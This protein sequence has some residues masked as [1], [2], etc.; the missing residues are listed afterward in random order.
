MLFMNVFM[1]VCVCNSISSQ[2]LTI[3]EIRDA[4]VKHQCN[5]HKENDISA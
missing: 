3:M 1:G 4:E 2:D 5:S